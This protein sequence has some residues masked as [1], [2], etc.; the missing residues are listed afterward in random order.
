MVQRCNACLSLQVS[1]LHA[2]HATASAS[3]SSWLVAD[4]CCYTSN[5][6]VYKPMIM[7][8]ASVDHFC[9]DNML[10]Q[11]ATAWYVH[12]LSASPSQVVSDVSVA[13][14]ILAHGTE[15]L[16]QSDGSVTS[17]TVNQLKDLLKQCRE[18]GK[19]LPMVVANPDL[20]SLQTP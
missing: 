5:E 11:L 20:V 1:L 8:T 13:D 14:F 9:A 19:A 6:T 7:L 3:A 16:A 10:H 4:T 15:G 18:C 2:G 12:G 17:M